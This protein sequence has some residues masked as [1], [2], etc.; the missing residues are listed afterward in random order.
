M[1][2]LSGFPEWYSPRE[3]QKELISE[4]ESKLKSGYTKIILCAPTGVGKSLIGTTF[5][6]HFERS[7]T[8]TASKH[9]QDQYIRDIP[10][11]KP[12]KGKTNFACLKIMSS[13]KVTDE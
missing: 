4:I 13:E 7:F 1:S 8:I 2:L 11:L 10:I 3:I 5:A 12:V 6:R 9:L